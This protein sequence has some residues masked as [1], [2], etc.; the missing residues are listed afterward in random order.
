MWRFSVGYIIYRGIPVDRLSYFGILEKLNDFISEV[1]RYFFIKKYQLRWYHYREFCEQ[2]KNFIFGGFEF[3]HISKDKMAGSMIYSDN[4]VAIGYNTNMIQSRQNFTQ[5]HEINHALFD[6]KP[7][8]PF[9]NFFDLLKE[10]GYNKEENIQEI[11]ADIGASIFMISDE[12]LIYNIE[13]KTSFSD[14]QDIFEISKMALEI[15]LK[16][17]LVYNLDMYYKNAQVLIEKY[18][19]FNET[20]EIQ[21]RMEI[22]KEAFDVKI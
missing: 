16:N 12:A 7:D 15:R 14:L 17:F 9:Q 10:D 20:K 2:E 6:L 3:N 11:R 13:K 18:K 19:F 4:T 22:Y 21:A 8:I 1:A 5:M